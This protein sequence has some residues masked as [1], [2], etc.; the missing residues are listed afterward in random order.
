[1]IL[2][3]KDDLPSDISAD[4]FYIIDNELHFSKIEGGRELNNDS[5]CDGRDLIRLREGE[6]P[7]LS[8]EEMNGKFY[9]SNQFPLKMVRITFSKFEYEYSNL[10]YSKKYNDI[11]ETPREILSEA[12]FL[13]PVMY[14]T[15]AILEDM[16]TNPY[17]IFVSRLCNSREIYEF[18]IRKYALEVKLIEKCYI[19]LLLRI[20]DETILI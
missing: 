6:I 3:T 13:D 20:G 8:L 17:P 18:V 2:I 1:M 5:I 16:E 11:Y 4:H 9:M 12:I 14:N 10:A 7:F 15:K 19:N